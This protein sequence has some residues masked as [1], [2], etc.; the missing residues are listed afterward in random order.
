MKTLAHTKNLESTKMI[1]MES[2]NR[3]KNV[4]ISIVV[5]PSYPDKNGPKGRLDR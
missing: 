4:T 5:S 1:D 3:H 2:S